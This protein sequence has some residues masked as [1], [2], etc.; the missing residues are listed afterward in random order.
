MTVRE[1]LSVDPGN[2]EQVL[3]CVF[4]EDAKA[5]YEAALEM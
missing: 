1:E 2:L 5:A 3:F 4:G